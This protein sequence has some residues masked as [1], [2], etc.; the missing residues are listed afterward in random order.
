M[1]CFG[2]RW[3]FKIF[4]NA[5]ATLCPFGNAAFFF[6]TATLIH[7]LGE[8]KMFARLSAI[9]T[10]CCPGNLKKIAIVPRWHGFYT[11]AS[12]WSHQGNVRQN[13]LGCRKALG[14]AG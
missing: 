8:C 10:Q 5:D 4:V 6:V 11:C 9:L 12:P 7:F 13:D 2:I 3:T 14:F 1:Y